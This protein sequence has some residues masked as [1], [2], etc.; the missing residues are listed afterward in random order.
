MDENVIFALYVNEKQPSPFSL[1]MGMSSNQQE[2]T[3][4]RRG[5]WLWANNLNASAPRLFVVTT[6]VV[7][8]PYP[9][10]SFVII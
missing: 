1:R 9:K 4:Y 6:S 5:V 3:G 2:G 7:S 8:L 10:V